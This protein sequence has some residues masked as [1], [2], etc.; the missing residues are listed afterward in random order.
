[1]TRQRVVC[2]A[3]MG[4][5]RLDAGCSLDSPDREPLTHQAL[6]GLGF[7]RIRIL[8][9]DRNALRCDQNRILQD[10]SAVVK[11]N[12]MHCACR[13]NITAEQQ[14]IPQFEPLYD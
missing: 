10:G 12:G 14:T 8:D 6:A 1:M 3:R 13:G 4:A 11:N 9:Q 5:F 2:G 7:C